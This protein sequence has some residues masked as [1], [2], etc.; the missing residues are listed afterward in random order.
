MIP[1]ARVRVNRIPGTGGVPGAGVTEGDVVRQAARVTVWRRVLATVAVVA[2][3]GGLMAFA[4]FG[5]FSNRH[6]P[7][8]HS[9]VARRPR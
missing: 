6:D 3:A 8:T 2:V 9:V 5:S 7:F 4:A 1:R